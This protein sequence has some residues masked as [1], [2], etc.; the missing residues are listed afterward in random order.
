[1]EHTDCPHEECCKYAD[2]LEKDNTELEEKLQLLR[3]VIKTTDIVKSLKITQSTQWSIPLWLILAAVAGL[4]ALPWLMRWAFD[5]Y[6]WVL[7]K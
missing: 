7:F 6:T 4:A 5:Y 2:D 1:M 3:L